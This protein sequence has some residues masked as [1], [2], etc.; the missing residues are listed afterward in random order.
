MILLGEWSEFSTLSE[1]QITWRLNLSPI[2]E[3]GEW[4]L[5]K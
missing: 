2:G 1:K 4:D 5:E 3:D